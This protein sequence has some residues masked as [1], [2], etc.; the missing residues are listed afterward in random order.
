MRAGC[1]SRVEN[2]SGAADRTDIFKVTIQAVTKVALLGHRPSVG[3]C[4]PARVG[5]ERPKRPISIG[6]NSYYPSRLGR[7]CPPLPGH[8]DVGRRQRGPAWWDKKGGSAGITP[9]PSGREFFVLCSKLK[10][11]TSGTP[12][13]LICSKAPPPS[14]TGLAVPGAESPPAPD[15]TCAPWGQAH[16]SRRGGPP[17]GS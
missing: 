14:P 8:G 11:R 2:P 3:L 12:L 15:A 9:V 1:R 17:R 10:N 16:L 7:A 13:P 6:L 5:A 4:R